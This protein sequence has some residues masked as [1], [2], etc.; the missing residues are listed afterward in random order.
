MPALSNAMDQHASMLARI[1]DNDMQDAAR[2]A[3]AR[4]YVNFGFGDWQ[5]PDLS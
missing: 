3:Y 1:V 4:D 5:P 2:A